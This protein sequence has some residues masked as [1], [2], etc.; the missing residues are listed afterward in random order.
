MYEK[1]ASIEQED[2][3][4]REE[5]KRTTQINDQH[6]HGIGGSYPP[7]EGRTVRRHARCIDAGAKEDATTTRLE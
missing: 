6:E 3:R 5:R 7:A 1:K 2:E 4:K